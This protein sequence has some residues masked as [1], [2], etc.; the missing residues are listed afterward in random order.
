MQNFATDIKDTI[1]GHLGETFPKA[2]KRVYVLAETDKYKWKEDETIWN[3]KKG[4]TAPQY[5]GYFDGEF[6][7]FMDSAKGKQ[8]NLIEYLQGIKKLYQQGK[9]FV[10]QEMYDVKLAEAN[11]K[12]EDLIVPKARSEAEGLIVE[13]IKKS[14]KKRK[15]KVIEK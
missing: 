3:Q 1:V 7:C 10:H 5:E 14:A 9:I 2:D 8:H 15:R 4:K 6:V 11:K 13:S 12:K